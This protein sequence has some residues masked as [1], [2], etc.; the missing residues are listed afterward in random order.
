MTRTIIL[1]FSL[2]FALSSTALAESA[3]DVIDRIIAAD[4]ANYAGID[5]IFQRTKVMGHITPEYFEKKGRGHAPG[6]VARIA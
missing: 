1:A 6:S 5:N 4:S 3:A 2:C